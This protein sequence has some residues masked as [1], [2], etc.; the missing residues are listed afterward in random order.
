MQPRLTTIED[1]GRS[2]RSGDLRISDL[3]SRCLKEIKNRDSDIHAFLDVY[4]SALEEAQ[5]KEREL[6]DAPQPSPLFGIPIAIKDNI[7]IKGKRATAGS[8]ILENYTAAYD[9]T[10]IRKLKE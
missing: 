9:A 3:V 8:K 7:L 5:K 4:D 2:I 6:A 1:A 10:V